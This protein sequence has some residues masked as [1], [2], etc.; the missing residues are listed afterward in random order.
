[1]ANI[2]Q[3]E[4]DAIQRLLRANATMGDIVL[5]LKERDLTYSATGW[6][7]LF[8]KRIVPALR[9]G[10]LSRNDLVQWLRDAEEY[11]RQH[12]F[13]YQCSKA[14]ASQIVNENAVKQ[15]LGRLGRTDLLTNP[16]VVEEPPQPTVCDVRFEHGIFGRALVVKV[17]EIR[18]HERF[19]GE[20]SPSDNRIIR[21]YER[22]STRAVSVARVHED[23]FAEMRVYS[24]RTKTDYTNELEELWSICNV[25]VPRLRFD[26]VSIGNAQRN[27]WKNRRQLGATI[28]YTSSELHDEKGTVLSAATGGSNLSLFDTDKAAKSLDTFWDD[29]ATCDRSN[30]WWIKGDPRPSR[31]I[32]ILMSGK[33]NE[34]TV[35]TQCNR[36]DYDYVLDQLRKA[37]KQ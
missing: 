37:N 11:G 16:R 32:H 36:E 22:V 5:Q 4:L 28:R 14:A 30:V 35:T 33:V 34:L 23:G 1:M 10:S 12:V 26:E 18:Y 2:N 21:E 29:T 31:D 25:F 7:D 13:I 17:V 3:R 6:D 15:E 9:N 8:T 24:H 19:V 20:S 27:L